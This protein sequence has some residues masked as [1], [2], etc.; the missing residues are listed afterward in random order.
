[1]QPSE[2]ARIPKLETLHFSSTRSCNLG[3]VFCYARATRGRTEQ[4][5]LDIVGTIAREAAELGAR[6]VILSGGEPLMRA[7][8]RDVASIFDACQM[9]V[10]LATNGTL[11]DEEAAAFLQSLRKVTISISVDGDEAVHD[12]LRDEPGA[13]R[14][15]MRALEALTKVGIA[16]DVNTTIFREN[17][18]QVSFLTKLSRDYHCNVRLTLLHPNGRGKSVADSALES[19]E[20][21]RLREYCHII[22]QHGGRIFLNL[23]PL[24]QYVE[25]IIPS[26]GV[27]CGWAVNFCGVLPNGDVS[28]C[29]VAD[30]TPELVA[31]NVFQKSLMEIWSS[32]PLFQKTRSF[33]V[34]DLRGVCGCCPFKG[35]CGGACR[36]S[37]FRTHNDLLA[38]YELCQRFYD[39]G[40]IPEE[41]LEVPNAPEYKATGKQ[42]A[43]D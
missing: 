32:S 7:D 14:R 40:Y 8:W 5:P 35:L 6:R 29:G 1:M 21:L 12:R 24:L 26:R 39:L 19:E 15:T 2:L 22:G 42:L 16:F 13:H 11:I 25:D 30:G 17:L 34:K 33:D 41:V 43:S 31:G 3:C 10:S 20:I 23:P 9:E 37:A 36:L 27:A 4:L 18:S 38:P 28:I